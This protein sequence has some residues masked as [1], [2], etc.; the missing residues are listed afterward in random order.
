MPGDDQRVQEGKENIE[1]HVPKRAVNGFTKPGHPLREVVQV[2]PE[3]PLGKN[4]NVRAKEG[5]DCVEQDMMSSK[6]IF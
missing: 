5:L 3:Q 1:S 2:L 4:S 6:S